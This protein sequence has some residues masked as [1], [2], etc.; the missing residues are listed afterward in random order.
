MIDAGRRSTVAALSVMTLL[1]TLALPSGVH[2]QTGPVAGQSVNMVS[3]TEWPGGDPFLQ[4][5]NEPALAISSLNVE[6]LL[7]GANTYR[8]VDIPFPASSETGDAWLGLY[9]SLDGGR[10]W[11]TYLLPGYPQDTS[12]EAAASPL[13]ALG[14]RAA[15]DA[16]VRAGTNGFFGMSG[17][18]FNRD[19][20]KGVVFFARHIDLDMKENG[21]AAEGLD[22]IPYVDTIVIDEGNSGQFLDKPWFAI[23]IPRP[24]AQGTCTITANLKRKQGANV[25]V[26]PVTRTFPVGP[27]YIAWSRFT[28]SQ[29]TKIMVSRSLD[30]GRTWSNAVKVSEG[31][32]INQG[33]ALAI[34]PQTG[35][36]YVAW[37]RFKTSSQSDAILVARSDDGQSFPGSQTY[38]IAS[39]VPFDQ[40]TSGYSFRTSALPTMAVSVSGT[41]TASPVSRVHVAWAQRSEIGGE[42]RIVVST[43]V[44]RGR[45]WTVPSAVDDGPA[46][47]ERS[48]PYVTNDDETLVRGHQVMPQMTFSG[49]KLMVL[50][51]DLRL[52]HTTGLYE[53]KTPFQPDPVDGRFYTETREKRGEL[54]DAPEAVHKS[55]ISDA[56]PTAT[57][58][59]LLVRRHTLDLRVSQADAAA[60]LTWQSAPV[61]RYPFGTR[62]DETG[63]ITI[64]Q[65]L[66]VN[67]PNLPLFQQGTVPFMGDYIDIAGEAFFAAE[68]APGKPWCSGTWCYRLAPQASPVHYAT[69]TS[70][71]DVVPPPPGKTWSDYTPVGS[72]GQSLYDPS[73]TRPDCVPGQE[74]MRNQ[75]VY[76]SRITQGLL[77]ASPQA[78]KPLSSTQERAFVVLANNETAFAKVFRLRIAGQPVGGVASFLARTS[79]EDPNA[80]ADSAPAPVLGQPRVCTALDVTI[81]PRSGV[82]RSVFATSTSPAARLTV[83]VDQIAAVGATGP[84]AG[85]L[86]G[87][88]LLNAVP[89]AAL[90]SPDD[91]G[92][93][94][95]GEIYDPTIALINVS[96]PNVSNINVSNPNVSNVNVSNINV[97]NPNVSNINVSN[98][99]IADINVSNVNVSNPNVS[100][101]NVSNPNVSNINVSNQV[102][103]DASYSITNT[104]NTTHS[105][106]VQL[107]GQEPS[108]TPIQLILTKPYAPPAALGCVLGVASNDATL[109]SIPTPQVVPPGE[110]GDPNIPDAS[111]ANATLSL[112]PGETAI[113]TIRGRTDV[114]G[115]QQVISQLAPA[116]VAHGHNGTL[117][118]F[119]TLLLVTTSNQDL[120]TPTVGVYYELLLQSIGGTG[121]ISWSFQGDL[122]PGLTLSPTGTISGTPT[123]AGSF[124]TQI[125]ASD[126]SDPQQSTTRTLEFS[127]SARATSTALA[128]SPAT[129]AAGTS[130]QATVIVTDTTAN[131]AK[132][133]PSGQVT[134]EGAGV[135]GGSCTLAASG[136]GQ[137]SC[138]VGVFA[139][140]PGSYTVTASYG[141]STAHAGSSASASLAA[142]PGTTSTAILTDSP[143]PSTALD[144]VTVTVSVTAASAAVGTPT[145]TVTVTDGA[146]AS[147]IITLPAASCTLTS[148]TAGTREWTASY[149]GDA[150]FGGSSGKAWHTVKGNTTKTINSDT[151]DPSTP[152]QPVTVEV[153]VTG[154]S[155]VGTPGG[156][157]AVSGGGGS[158]SLTLSSG[159]GS[160]ALTP[161]IVGADQT[162]T[163]TYAGD[164]AFTGSAGTALHTVRT[165]PYAFT[166]FASPLKTAFAYPKASVSGTWNFSRVLPLKWQ[167]KTSSGTVVTSASAVASI[168]A[169]YSGTTCTT[170]DAPPLPAPPYTPSSG[171]AVLYTPAQGAAGGSDFRPGTTYNFNWDATRNAR[172]G[173]WSI[174]VELDDASR[175][176]TK[177]LLR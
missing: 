13:K 111:Q 63:T 37:R 120:G 42:S 131:G 157:V 32:S 137:S 149:G 24:F 17:I 70:N 61:S 95:G 43:S 27:M 20:N 25:E 80:C 153:T 109:A 126:E 91:A 172:P 81:P 148:T 79:Q 53:P 118:P 142:G 117:H 4:R 30:C 176:A 99:D 116:V 11:K 98:A 97:S 21:D 7:A 14:L 136:P 67:P 138:W 101:I 3:G 9:K 169:L 23:D 71:Q 107:V 167:L 69:W 10:T 151:P 12:P 18:A 87:F 130:S 6:R 139:L 170:A 62:G 160:C 82:A 103:S 113:V 77:V 106:H 72:G 49:G 50:Y 89:V 35:A 40:G 162:W 133:S 146:G 48:Q 123:A 83:N 8:T 86:S 110:L 161:T 51:Y 175:W 108:T 56:P 57:E 52:T 1:S 114:A 65:Q 155:G 36:V 135:N 47:D 115:M 75:N 174:V 171:V 73:Q 96:N 119:A 46:V 173:C 78:N 144:L 88:V 159:T 147:C 22:T 104:G 66:K 5:D 34:D 141:G 26:I 121:T 64:L 163:A 68:Q 129:V 39:F 112:A 128:L 152:G 150:L 127:V 44:N 154:T 58:P 125:T 158:C 92:N 54:V 102:I 143:D 100:N 166:G 165:A 76:A 140:A 59:G 29:S 94:S 15:A 168:L 132:A 177:V 122:P 55:Y 145:G 93:I 41:D 105:Y 16:T 19:T 90:A 85:G 45:D 60:T 28:G 164:G 84:L 31:N 134:V 38:E 2:A 33:T 74:G 124:F 156:S